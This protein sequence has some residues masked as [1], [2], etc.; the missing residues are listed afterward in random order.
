MMW[1]AVLL[2]MAI[3]LYLCRNIRSKKTDSSN[4]PSITPLSLQQTT[5]LSEV[6][7]YEKLDEQKKEQFKLEVAEFLSRCR[8]T[9]IE[10]EVSER[11]R[12]LIA[13]SAVIPVF[14]FPDWK[15][16]TIDEV[17]LYPDSFNYDYSIGSHHPILGMV[18]EGALEGKMVLSKKALHL[19]FENKTDK[20]NTA[21]HEFI[22]LIDM[23]D[24]YVDGVP[25]VLIQH[26]YVLPWLQAI[27]LNIDK[28]KKGS[29]DINPYGAT[30]NQEFLAVVGEYFFERPELL[31]RK[32][33]D[34]YQHME[35]MFG[36]K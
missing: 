9:G 14:N 35:R 29:S 1:I 26:Q 27:Q 7:F 21:I 36:P 30:N 32:H 31:K 3:G 33:P 2:V 8:I 19:G 5:Y 6:L 25:E 20:N 11:D 15:Y 22:H 12:I 34:L 13:S 28:I 24:G 10:T 16:S 4:A 23:T 18:G 17:L